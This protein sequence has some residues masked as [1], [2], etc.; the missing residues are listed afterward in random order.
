M[1][2]DLCDIFIYFDQFC[3]FR[4]L[5]ND[6]VLRCL[7]FMLIGYSRYCSTNMFLVR[8]NLL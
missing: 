7:D 2:L 4:L 3:H 6:F 5:L 1:Q 8:I